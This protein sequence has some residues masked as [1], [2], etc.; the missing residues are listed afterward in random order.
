MDLI[1]D[2]TGY[3]ARSFSNGYTATNPGRLVD[4]RLGV[5]TAKGSVRSGGSFTVQIAGN[6]VGPL[7]AD[8]VTAVALNVTVTGPQGGG[9]LTVFPNGTGLPT[10]SNR[11]YS[12]GQTIANAV[13]APVGA[14]GKI[15][16]YNGSWG[17]ADVVVD[18]VGYYSPARAS[19]YLPITPFRW[20]DT[21]SWGKGPPY[22]SSRYHIYSRFGDPGD[23][24]FVLNTT[25]TNTT[26]GG[27][28]TVSPDPNNIDAYKGKYAGRPNRPLVST[29]NWKKGETVSNLVHATPGPG[30]IIDVWNTGTGS[31]DLVVD[32]FGYYTV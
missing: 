10:A 4:T 6:N 19:A 15:K 2:I 28:L 11:N 27:Y 8:G 23:T 18:V 1:A 5:G 14:D 9:S 26:G 29:L 22:D 32:V 16:I 30:G 31:T 3:F 21:R 12:P 17:S 7:P 25:V 13:I 24:G 20:L